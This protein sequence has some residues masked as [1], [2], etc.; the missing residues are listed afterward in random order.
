M[1]VKIES[2]GQ[3][4]FIYKDGHPGLTLG[5]ADIKRASDVRYENGFWRI[6]LKKETVKEN[7][8]FPMGQEKEVLIGKPHHTRAGAIAEEVRILNALLLLGE[9][10]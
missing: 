7:G 5:K 8:T 4:T 2:D 3:I 9:I 6:F 10:R 1:T